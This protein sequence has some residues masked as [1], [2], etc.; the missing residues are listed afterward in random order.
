MSD[1]EAVTVGSVVSCDGTRIGYRRIGR[2]PGLV[3]VQGAMGTAYNYDE[4]ARA[5][6]PAFTVYAPD[7]RGRGL[8]PKPYSPAHDLA[9]DVED[10]DAVLAAAGTGQL[11]GL[12]SGAMIAL[13]ATRMLP[14]VTRAAVYEP[15]F[16]PR[17]LAHDQIT[18]FNAEVDRGDLASA[19]VTAGR[20]VGLAPMPVRV[21]PKPIARL[22]TTAVIR[23]DSRTKGPYA[24]LRELIPT[25]RYD[26]NVVG[27]M[28]GRMKT[29]RSIRRSMLLLSGT[30]SPAYL[31]HAVRSL[32]EVLPNSHHTEFK[33][34]DHSGAWNKARG[35]CPMVVAA[36]LGDF[37]GQRNIPG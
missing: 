11:F 6:A 21:L 35:G 20:L 13:E 27:G 31:R 30:N 12:S 15:P 7:R 19:L 33:G 29:M 24:H 8:S 17:G 34:L 18:L 16:Y 23:A 25:M 36:A 2:G 10:I 4:L 32:G 14:R 22:F 9:R 26:F 5:L 3:L 28:D 1:L 37:F